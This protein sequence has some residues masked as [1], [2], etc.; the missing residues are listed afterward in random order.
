MPRLRV[1]HRRSDGPRPR[2]GHARRRD[3]QHGHAQPAPGRHEQRRVGAARRGEPA[4]V[5]G[6]LARR[7]RRRSPDL[8]GDQRSARPHVDQPRDE[9]AL[10]AHARPRLARGVTRRVARARGTGGARRVGSPSGLPRAAGRLRPPPAAHRRARTRLERVAGELDRRGA[11]SRDPHHRLRP[12]LRDLQ[13]SHPAVPRPRSPASPAARRGAADPDHLRRQGPSRRRAGQGASAGGGQGG[14]R[15]RAPPPA[16]AARGLRHHGGADARG[17]R[18]RVAQHAAAAARGVRHV[19]HEGGVQRRA[20]LLDPRRL[21]GRDVRRRRRLGHPVRRV[22]GRPRGPQR[23][24][25]GQLVQPARAPGRPPLL[26][27]RRTVCRST[28]CAR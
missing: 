27:A 21:V 13:A 26:H 28:G 17:R 11:R 8:V 3:V 25:G 7:A 12:S 2:A 9:L 23:S 22:A 6:D 1:E 4:D 16:G 20:Q 5:L 19:G 18:R 24:R 15:P 14:R 10:R